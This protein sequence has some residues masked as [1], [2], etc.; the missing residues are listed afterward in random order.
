M[1]YLLDANVFIAAKNLHYG[2]DFCPA[3]WDWLI[4][5]QGREAEAVI[6][7]LGAP[8]VAQVG[9]RN[10]AGRRPNLLN[11]A[12]TRAKEALYVIGNRTLWREAG[13]F[14]A[15]DRRLPP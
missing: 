9:A 3:F 8:S 11:V 7:V 2:L 14:S 5:V 15:L 4:T 1:A 6:F 13:V 10:W 12:A